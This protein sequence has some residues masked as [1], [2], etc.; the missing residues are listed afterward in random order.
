MVK[1]LF[2]FTPIIVGE[3]DTQLEFLQ[4]MKFICKKAGFTLVAGD[5]KEL[6]SIDDLQPMPDFD[7]PKETEDT[8]VKNG[9]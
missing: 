1:K 4:K 3:V 9:A 5:F 6:T 2:S 8:E 7:M